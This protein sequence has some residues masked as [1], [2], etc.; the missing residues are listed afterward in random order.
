MIFN[1]KTTEKPVVYCF[2]LLSW[3][4]QDLIDELKSELSGDMENLVVAMFLPSDVF[5]ARELHKAMKVFVFNEK[6]NEW[7]FMW[8]FTLY[9]L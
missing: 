2:K 8:I 1:V 6:G 9:W 7:G 5:Y 4:L 3:Y